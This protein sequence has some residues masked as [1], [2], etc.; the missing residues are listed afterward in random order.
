MGEC[1]GN[2]PLLGISKLHWGHFIPWDGIVK[3]KTRGLLCEV[4]A[5]VAASA[6]A[7]AFA[8]ACVDVVEAVRFLREGG[9]EENKEE[10]EIRRRKVQARNPRGEDEEEDMVSKEAQNDPNPDRIII[11]MNEMS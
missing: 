9:R 11:I 5:T 1:N 7:V 2:P 8:A 3:D 6:A 4:V 10:E